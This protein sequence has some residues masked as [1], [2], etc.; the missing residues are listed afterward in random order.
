MTTPTTQER[1]DFLEW[2]GFHQLDCRK[3][4]NPEIGAR[5]LDFGA[6][7]ESRSAHFARRCAEVDSAHMYISE[8]FLEHNPAAIPLH[9]HRLSSALYTDREG[10]KGYPPPQLAEL[11]ED[12]REQ[13]VL[14]LLADAQRAAKA[15]NPHYKDLWEQAADVA[16]LKIQW[17]ISD[18]TYDWVEQAYKKLRQEYKDAHL[19][20]VV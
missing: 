5:W 2:Y 20:A 13:V 10:K 15:H 17:H 19:H 18:R 4:H 14:R 1:N 9:I 11:V 6:S 7:L 12:M 16:T 3:K 8:Y